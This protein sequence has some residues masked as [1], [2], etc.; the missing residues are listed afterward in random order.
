MPAMLA[1]GALSPIVRPAA[2]RHEGRPYAFSI[3]RG[4]RLA[5]SCRCRV[6]LAP[7]WGAWAHSHHSDHGKYAR[8]S[9]A[10]SGVRARRQ[11]PRADARLHVYRSPNTPAGGACVHTTVGGFGDEC[12]GNGT[13]DSAEVRV[14]DRRCYRV[15]RDCRGKHRSDIHAVVVVG[16]GNEMVNSRLALVVAVVLSVLCIPF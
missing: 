8:R 13:A 14:S 6:G 4:S 5:L 1:C 10:R 3:P 9:G 12:V 16:T 7:G 2:K 15:H 11:S